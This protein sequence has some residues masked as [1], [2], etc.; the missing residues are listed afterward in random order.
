VNCAGLQQQQKDQTRANE[1]FHPFYNFIF[2]PAGLTKYLT[3]SPLDAYTSL[4]SVVSVRGLRFS[5]TAY[6]FPEIR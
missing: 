5:F 2:L 6:S 3:V 1:R 4:K